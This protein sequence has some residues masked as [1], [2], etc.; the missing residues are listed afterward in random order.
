MQTVKKWFELKT[1]LGENCI[2]DKF[3]SERR[4][5]VCGTQA[6]P[7]AEAVLVNRDQE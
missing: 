6:A 7:K 4:P 3:N 5:D 1:R 2:I